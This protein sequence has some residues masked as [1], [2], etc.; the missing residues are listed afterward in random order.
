MK[1]GNSQTSIKFIDDICGMEFNSSTG[2]KKKKKNQ[3]KFPQDL[4]TL[5][6]KI[7]FLMH[8]AHH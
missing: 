8:T 2:K 6:F 7:R 5:L 3:L 1:I 4:Q